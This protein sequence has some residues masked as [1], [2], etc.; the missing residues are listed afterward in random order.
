MH[1]LYISVSFADNQLIN[2][3]NHVLEFKEIM[4]R[5]K[6]KSENHH[7][8]LMQVLYQMK[9]KAAHTTRSSG[10]FRACCSCLCEC[11]SMLHKLGGLDLVHLT[12]GHFPPVNNLTN[13]DCFILRHVEL[14]QATWKICFPRLYHDTDF[15]ILSPILPPM[16]DQFN[17]SS[18]KPWHHLTPFPSQTSCQ[19]CSM[20]LR[21]IHPLHHCPLGT[22]TFSM[23]PHCVYIL[24]NCWAIPQRIITI[25]C[26]HFLEQ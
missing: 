10:N 24:Q 2:C 9:R 23:G 26:I 22:G 5:L 18:Q 16:H 12:L 14:R 8:D 1:K 6:N 21:A 13:T 4:L 7:Q 15:P 3:R 11:S 17:R 19:S 25:I 20:H